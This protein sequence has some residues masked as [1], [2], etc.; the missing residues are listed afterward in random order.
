LD[1][2]VASSA[3]KVDRSEGSK[4]KHASME[5][6]LPGAW[7]ASPE[8]EKTE[9]ATTVGK[10]VDIVTEKDPDAEGEPVQTLTLAQ[11][12]TPERPLH[13]V[14]ARVASPELV[15]NADDEMRK[16]EAGL[17][18]MMASP[19]QNIE[20]APRSPTKRE[21]GGA[22]WVLVNVEGKP[23]AEGEVQSG[24]RPA[25][26]SRNASGTF[27]AADLTT[28][29]SQAAATLSPATKI[30][31]IDAKDTKL[32]K[33][34]GKG[35]DD[36]RASGLKRLLSL[37][38]RGETSVEHASESTSPPSTPRGKK[39]QRT[40]SRTRLRDRLKLKGV[41]EASPRSVNDKR[42]SIN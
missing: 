8:E 28:P 34:K 17:V 19:A 7:S 29:K 38:K 2:E 1:L 23:R 3:G 13:D 33:D 22:G 21:G 24:D 15:S 42:L 6:Q 27:Q 32:A 20:P 37:S 5:P 11:E 18:G 41:P 9:A 35:K 30:V 39:G 36:I 40:P 16:S 26:H 31:I 12:K 10:A 14:D 25:A 4:L